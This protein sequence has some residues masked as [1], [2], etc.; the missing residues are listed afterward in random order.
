MTAVD[1]LRGVTEA[2]P[3]NYAY[4]DATQVSLG[5]CSAAD[6]ALTVWSSVVSSARDHAVVD[7]GALALS[8]RGRGDGRPSMAAFSKTSGL[9]RCADARL[10]SLS[11]GTGRGRAARGHPA[12]DPPQPLVSHERA[13]STCAVRGEDLVGVWRVRRERCRGARNL[14]GFFISDGSWNTDVVPSGSYA[15]AP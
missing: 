5:A 12:C 4:F 15:N 14:W 3:G 7:A 10:V 9:E 6:C 11:Q 13:S 8:G 2:R 1:H